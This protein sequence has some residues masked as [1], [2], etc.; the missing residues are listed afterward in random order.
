VGLERYIDVSPGPNSNYLPKPVVTL[1]NTYE[2][3]QSAH[4][5]TENDANVR[6]LMR[7]VMD[8]DE[9]REVE[10]CGTSKTMYDNLKRR[11]SGGSAVTLFS[12]WEQL[13]NMQLN[14][15]SAEGIFKPVSEARRLV[16]HIFTIGQPTKDTVLIMALL[17]A[18][19]TES[20]VH[21]QRSLLG[22]IARDELSMDTLMTRLWTEADLLGSNP[23]SA[24]DH[25]IA[26]TITEDTQCVRCAGLGHIAR[27]CP[28]SPHVTTASHVQAA[29][30]NLLKPTTTPQAGPFRSYI[31]QPAARRRGAG[32]G[33]RGAYRGSRGGKRGGYANAAD[34]TQTPGGALV[35]DVID[36][37]GQLYYPAQYDTAAATTD[38]ASR[39]EESWSDTDG[40]GW[41][42]AAR[43][44]LTAADVNVNHVNALLAAEPA[45]HE[46]DEVFAVMTS[47][48]RP[49]AIPLNAE[50]HE[51][52]LLTTNPHT[53]AHLGALEWFLDSGATMHCTPDLD[54]LTDAKDITP[55]PIRGVNGKRIYASKI[56]TV[57]FKLKGGRRLIV[58]GV[59]HLPDAALRLISVGRLA[60]AGMDTRFSQHH[61]TVI[62]QINDKS[63]AT[64][65]RVGRGL[66]SLDLTGVAEDRI[67][68]ATSGVPIGTWHGRLGHPAADAVE[69]LART[70]AVTGMHVDLSTRP[71]VCQP[72]I[73]G[74]QKQSAMP[75]HRE[76]EK[77]AAY[78][79]LVFVDLTGSP[80]RTA[81]PNKE[82]YSMSIKDDH[83][84]WVW[85]F[86]LKTK[87]Q[88]LVDL[89]SWHARAC[90]A[91]GQ[92]LKAIQIDNGELK[93]ED[94]DD[95]AAHHGIEIRYTAPYSSA[96]NGKI[97]R[98][99]HTLDN[100]ARAMR[101][102]ADLPE[103]L[104]GE[105]VK[106]A[107]YLHNY[108]LTKALPNGV[109][110][111]E[112]RKGKKPDV[113]HLREIGCKAFVLIQNRHI[114]K[115]EPRSIECIF[116]GYDMQSKAYRLW[117]RPSRKIV[118]SRN[119]QLVESHQLTPR[120]YRPGVSLGTQ[121][122]GGAHPDGWPNV[123]PAGETPKQPVAEPLQPA[124]AREEGRTNSSPSGEVPKRP[125]E[126][127]RPNASPEGEVPKRSDEQSNSSPE[128]E[129]PK[130][131]DAPQARERSPS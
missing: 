108:K 61:A 81:T 91:S 62:R 12:L 75:K 119:V 107:S 30:A 54:D 48:P 32:R 77:S 67:A 129:V 27:K 116:V 41:I 123:S 112:A 56:G 101:I 52:Y 70:N 68:A 40:S 36:V 16:D 84:S 60:D 104:W 20:A 39:E 55:V 69:R 92:R 118:V 131:S 35:P 73:R 66:Y 10:H 110:P 50:H 4:N 29:L 121:P 94:F 7:G 9:Y 85:T 74:K 126:P 45:V 115:I 79:D 98:T 71:P 122:G 19:G 96:Q 114:T 46:E 11:H 83:T 21:L 63:M 26:I 17:R 82:H 2:T 13:M 23:S 44:D 87:K 34:G 90:V 93:S 24:M 78:L 37:G 76:G 97:E 18:M 105:F 33:G 3:Q 14:A 128:G 117:H 42:G 15:T 88:A 111:Y 31:P 49:P 58:P 120:T 113:S 53:I 5:W 47:I 6:R 59:L 8:A 89:K 51:P 57:F 95:W 86:L 80:E 130:C 22:D 127:E 99:H 100:C 125:S 72:C 65:T 124:G 28:S 64:A 106:T 38:D 43:I 109:T 103:T 102:A 25:T 1:I